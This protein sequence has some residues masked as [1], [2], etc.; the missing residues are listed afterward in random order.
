MAIHEEEPSIFNG[1]SCAHARAEYVWPFEFEPAMG[2]NFPMS[3]VSPRARHLI[4]HWQNQ[5]P[6][7]GPIYL[8]ELLSAL[9]TTFSAGYEVETL[10]GRVMPLTIFTLV[11]AESGVGKTT[12]Q[13]LVMKPFSQFT[14]ASKTYSELARKTFR[15]LKQVWNIQRSQTLKE[16]RKRIEQDKCVEDLNEKLTVVD[17][18][19]PLPPK[20]TRLL[21]RDVTW[22]ALRSMLRDAYPVGCIA[23]SD[24]A[25]FISEILHNRMA[26]FCSI[27]SGE[28][29]DVSKMH[30]ETYVSRPRISL[31]LMTQ[32]G[33]LRDF[34]HCHGKEFVDIGVSARFIMYQHENENS[35]SS[36]Y[37][38]GRFVNRLNDYDSWITDRLIEQ[39]G[40]NGLLYPERPTIIRLTE[41]A[42][43]A[44][45]QAVQRITSMAAPNGRY[46]HI[47]E[48]VRKYEE[49]IYRISGL[50][51][52]LEHHRE[53]IIHEKDIK[54]ALSFME[55]YLDHYAQLIAEASE[56]ARDRKA[57]VELLQFIHR[58]THI[59]FLSTNAILCDNF[60][61]H[62]VKRS[63]IEQYGPSHV[64]KST[65]LT[66]LI[67]AS[68]RDGLIEERQ[69]S[70][71]GRKKT[72]VYRLS[73]GPIG[74]GF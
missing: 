53:P 16:I 27:W 72:V 41:G 17:K 19:E 65:N 3:A 50:Y 4:A 60:G 58:T 31:A 39:F 57:T 49:H 38:Q 1:D 74:S 7:P 18:E 55:F 37:P 63:Y 5:H 32:P 25:D 45:R 12:A 28:P 9:S 71:L 29:I 36:W 67:G 8:I 51:A 35:P 42:R 46:E 52:L 44:L 30:E 66:R 26:V 68:I 70:I 43:S 14:L 64:R 62:F 15:R 23:N 24:S 10:D 40:K 20:Y 2:S 56:A 11:S 48:L 61:N 33:Y 69:I 22:A 6:L 21:M 34:L 47:R 73:S 54:C 59:P 13:T